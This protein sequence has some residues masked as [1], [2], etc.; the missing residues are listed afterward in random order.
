MSTLASSFENQSTPAHLHDAFLAVLPRI[1]LHAQ[2][3]FR[4][5]RCPHRHEDAVAESVALA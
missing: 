5:V 4:D 2:S 3:H 1:R